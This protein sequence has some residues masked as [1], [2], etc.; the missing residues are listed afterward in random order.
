MTAPLPTIVVIG[1]NRPKSLSRLLGSLIKARYPEGDIRLVISLDNSGNPEPRKVA[2]A[3]DWPHGEKRIIA[4]PERLGLRQHVLSC[5]DLT[6]QYGDVIILE[7]DLFVSPFF[8][9]YTSRALQAYADDAG[10]AG[11]SLY[12]VQFNQTANLP[13]TPIDDGDSAVHFIQMAASW[14]QAWSRQHW[15]GFRQW[16][17]SNGTDISHIEGIP[18]DIRGW[19]ESSWLKLFTA[20]IISHDLYFVYPFRSLSTN[21]GDPGQ[22]F[23]IA[24]SRFQVP[25]QQQPIDYQFAKR[26]N[27]VS[28]YDAFCELLP[29]CVKRQNPVLADYDFTVNLYGC[30]TCRSGLQLTRTEARGL[31][32]FSLSMK[33]MELSIL[34][35]IEGEGLALI[36]SADIDGA[37]LSRPKT[38]YDIYRFFYKF[39]SVRII[40]FGVMERLQLL[41][42]RAT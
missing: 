23:N 28:I 24:S 42:K 21:F 34:H 13:F 12:S 3:F 8:Y 40:L 19:P 38:E 41:F 35:N 30:K 16:L 29:A 39:P 7:D 5:G 22:H 17:A 32:N 1:Y 11:I 36:D 2:E 9:E 37:S 18:A 6:E 10:V 4:H 14:G 15:Q 26:E 31:H 25:I 33:P 27:S 20:Y